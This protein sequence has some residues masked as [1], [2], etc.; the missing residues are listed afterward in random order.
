VSAYNFG[1][2]VTSRNFY[3]LRAVIWVQLLGSLFPKIWDDKTSKIWR[4]F[5]DFDRKYLPN[6]VV[7]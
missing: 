4:D 3:T 2:G 5:F 6:G 7:E 1:M